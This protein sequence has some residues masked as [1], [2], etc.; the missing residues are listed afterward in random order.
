MPSTTSLPSPSP[1]DLGGLTGGD[2][3]GVLAWLGTGVGFGLVSGWA[4]GY[5]LKKVALFTAFVCG[6]AFILIQV[7]VVNRFLTVDWKAVA[8]FFG[9][10]SRTLSG[11]KAA[12]W[13][14]LLTHFPYAGAFGVGFFLGFRKG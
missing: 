8:A 5:A 9:D 3:S 7:M 6:L 13:G 10:A 14:M 11:P 2:L 1:P 12:W 4:V